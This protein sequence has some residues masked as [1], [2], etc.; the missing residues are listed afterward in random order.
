MNHT[1]TDEQLKIL[2]NLPTDLREI[3]EDGCWMHDVLVARVEGDFSDED[4]ADAWNQFGY[5]GNLK[6][7]LEEYMWVAN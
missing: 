4:I 5:L 1:Y 6:D 2:E 7:A 3:I